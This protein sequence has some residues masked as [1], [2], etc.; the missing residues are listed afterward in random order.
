MTEKIRRYMAEGNSCGGASNNWCQRLTRPRPFGL[1]NGVIIC[2]LAL[3]ATGCNRSSETSP[4][5]TKGDSSQKT[6]LPASPHE[7]SASQDMPDSVFVEILNQ[8]GLQM[9]MT[10]RDEVQKFIQNGGDPAQALAQSRK[11]FSLETIAANKSMGMTS[12]QIAYMQ[13]AALTAI[14]N[15][16]Y[17]GTMFSGITNSERE[18]ELNKLGSDCFA[19]YTNAFN[20][21]VNDPKADLNWR[22]WRGMTFLM[23]TAMRG[24]TEL[25]KP[26]IAKRAKL[27]LQSSQ[28]K[29]AVDYAEE[30]KHDDIVKLLQGA[31]ATAPA[32]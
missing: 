2:A 11:F 16:G 8:K 17:T 7:A 21:F 6:D 23:N 10:T 12:P 19:A 1:L 22:D 25:V 13:L 31:G 5:E 26:L 29:T 27:D 28:G 15:A 9:I 14:E 24:E 4:R 18:A 30:N 3:A 20:I 32:K